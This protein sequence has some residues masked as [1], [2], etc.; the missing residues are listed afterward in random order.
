MSHLKRYAMPRNWPVEVKKKI[1]IVRPMPGPHAINRCIPLKILIK[2]SLDYADTSRE[3]KKIITSGKVKVD[4]V[5]RRDVKFPVGLMDVI[6]LPDAKEAY[7][8]V[9]NR[10]GIIL[11]KI[12]SD[13][14]KKL[15]LIKNKVSVKKGHFQL[16]LHDGR[17]ILLKTGADAYKTGDSIVIQL[18]DNKILKH[19]KLEKGVPAFI[20]A[21]KNMGVSGT[22]KEIKKKKTMVEKS[23]IIFKTDEKEMETLKGYVFPGYLDLGESGKESK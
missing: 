9:L 20:Y 21:G 14:D 19:Y 2:D 12:K 23:V 1:F 5:I 18:S 11:K 3:A 16:N 8:V 17:N 13:S 7:R 6:E 10:R 22:I 15:C 4:G